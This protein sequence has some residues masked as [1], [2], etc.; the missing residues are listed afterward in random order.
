MSRIDDQLVRQQALDFFQEDAAK[1]VYR[2]D[3]ETM[4]KRLLSLGIV[5]D[6]LLTHNIIGDDTLLGRVFSEQYD[7]SEEGIVSVRDK[8]KICAKSLQN[9]HDPDAE[10]RGKNGKKVKGYSTNITETTDEPGK[11]SLITDVKVKGAS[12]ADN[13]F[14]Q[15]A[16][17]STKDVTGNDVQTVYTDGAYQSK[18]NRKFAEDNGI[19]FIAN[20]I[21]G[22]PSRF[23]LDM[24]DEHTLQVTDKTTAEVQTA[25]PVK[26]DDG[27]YLLRVQMER[28]LGGTSPKSKWTRLRFAKKL[29]P[30]LSRKGRNATMSRQ[31]CSNIASIRETTRPDTAQR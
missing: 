16:I 6:Y 9:P 24:T 19:E 22:K 3:S 26:E 14:V 25:I 29:N 23:D 7:K 12:A 4:G 5:I 13:G 10:Y 31:P 30:S 28:R 20:G 1:T 27:R 2:T 11:P 15:D 17:D 18:E 21:Q 8:K